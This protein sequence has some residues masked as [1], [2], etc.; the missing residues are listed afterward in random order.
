[1]REKENI[2]INNVL[3]IILKGKIHKDCTTLLLAGREKNLDFRQGLRSFC[4]KEGRGGR[5]VEKKAVIKNIGDYAQEGTADN[6]R[7]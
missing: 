6:K 2:K 5:S 4:G 7:K 3:R 1:M